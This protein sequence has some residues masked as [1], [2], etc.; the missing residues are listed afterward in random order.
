MGKSFKT[1]TTETEKGT[2][3]HGQNVALLETPNG[4]TILGNKPVS[5]GLQNRISNDEERLSV[6]RRHGDD[7]DDSFEY[8]TDRESSVYNPTTM[9]IR[10][11]MA[12]AGGRNS[13]HANNNGSSE[14]SNSNSSD[15]LSRGN[16]LGIPESRFSRWIPKD[17][18]EILEKQAKLLAN[19]IVPKTPEPERVIRAT[20]PQPTETEI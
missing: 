14:P 5:K 17:Q 10:N 6:Q 3:S 15:L 4:V 12:T 9:P 11:V 2:Q 18:R 7:E 20:T 19:R 1:S 16:Q 8:A 13:Q